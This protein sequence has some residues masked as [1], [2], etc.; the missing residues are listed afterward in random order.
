MPTPTSSSPAILISGL[1]GI[2]SIRASKAFSLFQKT[3]G[4]IWA[5]GFNSEGQLGD[6]TIVNRS[7]PIQMIGVNACGRIRGPVVQQEIKEEITSEDKEP[8]TIYPNPAD[9]ELIIELADD[10]KEITPVTLFD[11]FG[12]TIIQSHF[13]TGERTINM[14]TKELIFGMYFLRIE[15]QQGLLRRRVLVVH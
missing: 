15:T 7:A 11:S 1:S 3:D 2:S 10:A 5:S 6:G 8:I 13:N 12:K 4:T 14:D 9:G